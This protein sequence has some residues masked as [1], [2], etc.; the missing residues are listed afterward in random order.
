MRGRLAILL[1]LAALPAQAEDLAPIC[2]DRPGKGTS[3][4]TVPR[5]H[6]QFEA[7]LYDGIL[8]HPGG[9]SSE[10]TAL[11]ALLFKYGISDSGDIELGF[12]SYQH[13]STSAQPDQSGVG[14]FT[15]RSK[16]NLGSKGPLAVFIEPFVKIPTATD[17][18]GNGA[19]E[20][21]LLM[22]LSYDLGRGWSLGTTPEVDILLNASGSGRHA[23]AILPFGLGKAFDSGLSLSAEVWTAQ[24]FDPAGTS[25]LYSFDLSAAWLLGNDTQIDGGVNFGL[26]RLTPE[27]EFYCGISRRF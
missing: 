14:D 20:G 7:G 13:L 8:D 24:N 5:A 4:C 1:L 27:T 19:V 11:G 26:N 21:G 23:A 22:P 15:V 3:A 25:S 6:A 12:T 16:W 9:V 10:A 2:A 18:L 17:G